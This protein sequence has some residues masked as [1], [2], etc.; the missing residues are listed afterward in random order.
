MIS[1]K[2][3]V[4][5]LISSTPPSSAMDPTSGSK[6]KLFWKVSRANPL[7]KSIGGESNSLRPTSPGSGTNAAFGTVSANRF[8]VV[9]INC[10]P[11][12]EVI[13]PAGKNGDV[14]PS[15]FCEKTFVLAPSSNETDT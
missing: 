14:M 1:V 6:S 7:G 2:A 5:I 4:P 8:V 11:V 3:F 12:V 9:Q 15:K 13:Q 10:A